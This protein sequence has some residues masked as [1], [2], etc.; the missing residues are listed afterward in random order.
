MGRFSK[1]ILCI[2]METVTVWQIPASHISKML[3]LLDH[4][5]V[6][7]RAKELCSWSICRVWKAEITYCISKDRI[8]GMHGRSCIRLNGY[9]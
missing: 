8:F 3:V 5:V 2:G 7:S 6:V 1:C 4:I 9:E